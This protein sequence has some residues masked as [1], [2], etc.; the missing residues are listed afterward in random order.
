MNKYI[1]H[2]LAWKDFFLVLSH[3]CIINNNKTNR[4]CHK[5]RSSTIRSALQLKCMHDWHR[6]PETRLA[7]NNHLSAA[8]SQDPRRKVTLPRDRQVCAATRTNQ[9]Q[10]TAHSYLTHLPQLTCSSRICKMM[11]HYNP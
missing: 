6:F 2:I 10:C 3:H 9:S 11:N 1:T 5:Q 7:L 4:S 8:V